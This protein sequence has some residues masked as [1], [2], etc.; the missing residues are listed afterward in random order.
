VQPEIRFEV[1]RGVAT[2]TI[3]RPHRRNALAA[4]HMATLLALLRQAD[5]DPEIRVLVLTGAGEKAFCAG[6]DLSGEAV[7][8]EQLRDAPVTGLG[9]LIRAMRQ[10]GKPLIG[11]ING[12]CR[13]GGMGLLAMCDLAVAC[14]EASFGLSEID[15]GLFP[16]VVLAA[17]GGRAER[18]HALALTGEAVGAERAARIGLISH[19][20]SR[21]ALDPAVDRLAQS[22]AGKPPGAMRA[23]RAALWQQSD[24]EFLAAL[25]TAEARSLALARLPEAVEGIAA[26][27]AKRAPRWAGAG[28]TEHGK[29]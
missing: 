20:V 8:L 5:A 3:D 16:F 10:L 6:A 1:G 4:A 22:L 23:G 15:V 24:A 14:E 21:E 25:A 7:F 11:R 19:C 26:F 17:F 9:D 2:I 12:A 13:A 18:L 28:E 27:R 29:E